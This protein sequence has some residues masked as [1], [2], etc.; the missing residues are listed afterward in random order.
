MIVV[1]VL[2]WSIV[3]FV[4]FVIWL[5]W[6]DQRAIYTPPRGEL[7]KHIRNVAC[8]VCGAIIQILSTDRLR[9]QG[10][11]RFF[12]CPSCGQETWFDSNVQYDPM[13]EFG[14]QTPEEWDP[15]WRQEHS[16]LC[17]PPGILDVPGGEECS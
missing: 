13:T 12:V 1:K 4:I 17:V 8:K 6:Q 3:A 7:P 15:R 9:A 11:G 16:D 5:N 14:A 10:T 2:I